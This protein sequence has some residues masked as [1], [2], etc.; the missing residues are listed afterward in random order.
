M[1]HL[2]SATWREEGLNKGGGGASCLMW[3]HQAVSFQQNIKESE[4]WIFLDLKRCS[5]DP[6]RPPSVHWESCSSNITLC[7]LQPSN[8]ARSHG[9]FRMVT[10]ER[11]ERTVWFWWSKTSPWPWSIRKYMSKKWWRAFDMHSEDNME[12]MGR[13]NLIVQLR[14]GVKL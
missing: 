14:E 8:Q 10:K 2:T 11:L 1:R 13:S 3:H 12:H 7:R 5:D 6:V 4:I 9:N